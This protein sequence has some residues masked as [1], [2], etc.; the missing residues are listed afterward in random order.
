GPNSAQ[1]KYFPQSPQITVDTCFD[2]LYYP[3]SDAWF[4]RNHTWT[5][6]ANIF[7]NMAC[8]GMHLQSSTGSRPTGFSIL[9]GLTPLLIC[10][11]LCNVHCCDDGRDD[12]RCRSA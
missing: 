6:E 1:L 7:Q 8:K 12:D 9:R 3:T 10:R 2:Y 11:R 4:T 5:G